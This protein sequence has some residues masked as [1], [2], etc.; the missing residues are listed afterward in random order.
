MVKE[1]EE[2]KV[3]SWMECCG[4]QSAGTHL[5]ANVLKLAMAMGT[6]FP[7]EYTISM[8]CLH[9]SGVSSFTMKALRAI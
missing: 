7:L 8:F 4:D 2:I 1:E 5:G 6:G 9:V 3:D